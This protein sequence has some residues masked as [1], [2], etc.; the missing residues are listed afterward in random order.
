LLVICLFLLHACFN[1]NNFNWVEAEVN[2]A[3]AEVGE[4]RAEEDQP[5]ANEGMSSLFE[6]DMVCNL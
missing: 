1:N 4:A 5:E 2:W 6:E 3:E